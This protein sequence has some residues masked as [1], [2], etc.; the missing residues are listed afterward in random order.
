MSKSIVWRSKPA[1]FEFF[2]ASNNQVSLEMTPENE[3]N[4]FEPVCITLDFDD[5]KGI[6]QI[7]SDLRYDL[8]R[9]L[10]KTDSEKEATDA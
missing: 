4:P 3:D 1:K 5:L 2:I 9:E 8:E 6:E 10:R 7:V